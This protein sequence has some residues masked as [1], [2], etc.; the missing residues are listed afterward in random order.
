[1]GDILQISF[2]LVN[3]T[4]SCLVILLIVYW[5]F[6]M[7]SGIDTDLNLDIDID[8]EVDMDMNTEIDN[9]QTIY[10]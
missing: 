10:F 4:L 5:T 9:N 6:T 2:S 7:L 8:A 1:M 3:I